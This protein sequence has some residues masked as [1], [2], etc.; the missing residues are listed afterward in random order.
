MASFSFHHHYFRGRSTAIQELK[1]GDCP[2]HIIS[3]S[4]LG[5]DQEHDDSIAQKP[6]K[7]KQIKKPTVAGILDGFEKIGKGLKH[8]LS[9]QRKGD[10]KDI[11][12][13][14]LS[15]AVYV[16]ISQKI[17]RAYCA[18]VSMPKQPW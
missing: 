7:E 3:V 10:W 18:W 8:N 14:S 2:K 15:F 5:H 11:A 16:Y 4:C 17:V 9:P 1:R 6:K 13:M 12:L